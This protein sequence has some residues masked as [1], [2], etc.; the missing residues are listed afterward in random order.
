[1]KIQELLL[2]TADKYQYRTG[3]CDAFAIA[4]HHL[5]KLPLGAWT[6]FYYDENEQDYATETCHVCCVKSFEKLE[7]IDVDGLHRGT[8]EN[9]YFANKITEIKL[10]PISAADAAYLYTTT[11]V[12][13]E[14]IQQAQNF[15]L[16]DPNFSWINR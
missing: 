1:M 4:L 13:P 7:W 10:L 12:S 8:P 9:C 5:T 6:G 3:M 15:I 16:S 11:G 2:E 14:E